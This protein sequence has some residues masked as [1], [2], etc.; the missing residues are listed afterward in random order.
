MPRLWLPKRDDMHHIDAIPALGT[1]KTDLRR[2][3]QMAAEI[4]RVI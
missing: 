2:V 3:K 1:G 4:A